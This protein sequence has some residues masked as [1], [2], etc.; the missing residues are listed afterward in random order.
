MTGK[1]RIMIY[2]P[3]TYST[4][5]VEFRMADGEVLAISVPVGED[6]RAQAFRGAEPYGFS[7]RTFREEYPPRQEYSK[8]FPRRLAEVTREP[9]CK[10]V[11]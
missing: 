6:P 4:Y 8:H 10:L 7:C 3:K 2:G 1:S 11:K 9:L 5:V